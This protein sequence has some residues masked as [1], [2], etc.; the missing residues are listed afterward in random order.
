MI[1]LRIPQPWLEKLILALGLLLISLLSYGLLASKMGYFLDDWYIVST[2]RTFGASGFIGYFRGD[3]PLL[4]Y[5]YLL[6]MPIFKDSIPAW[7]IFAIFSKWLAALAF[8]VLLKLLFPDKK[9][10]P[11][12]TAMLFGIYPGFKFHYFVIMYSQ[13]YMMMAFYIVSYI[14]M[15]LSFRAKKHLWI[16]MLFALLCQLIGLAPMEYFFG[17]ELVRPV[18]VY[19]LVSDKEQTYWKNFKKTFQAWAPYAFV[20]FGYTAYR[21]LAGKQYSYKIN[22]LS[23]LHSS[24]LSTIISLLTTLLKGMFDSC[25]KAWGDFLSVLAESGDSRAASLRFGLIA[26]SFLISYLLFTSLHVK[27][28]E[29]KRSS[30]LLVILAVYCVLVAMIPFVFAGFQINLDFP[31]N[32]FMLPLSFGACLFIVTAVDQ[33]FRTQTQKKV[34]LALVVGSCVFGNYLNAREYKLAW[35]KQTDFFSQMLWRIP[36][37]K[38]ETTLLTPL[39]QFSTYFSGTSLTAPLNLIYAPENHSNPLP[40]QMILAASNEGSLLPALI[41]DQ[42]ISTGFRVFAFEGNTSDMLVIRVPEKGCLQL[43]SPKTNPASLKKEKYAELWKKILPLS[44][45]TRIESTM[46]QVE[47]PSQYFGS[48]NEQTW[49]YFYEKAELA[50]QNNNW[51]ESIALFE[52]AQSLSFKPE[53]SFEY[54]PFIRALYKNGKFETALNLSLALQNEDSFTK[55]ELCSFWSGEAARTDNSTIKEDANKI[56]QTLQCEW[57]NHD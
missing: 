54:L 35:Q 11:Y 12:A 23:D 18:I 44:N 10:L 56:M 55:S 16:L 43:L 2:Y 48:I 57:I 52:E 47:L 19:L 21:I 24:P 50:N 49:C 51:S 37:M 36:Q 22:L 8:W 1:K 32:R 40:Y 7:Q 15:L 4:S 34:I 53:N 26:A 30:G 42:K 9:L 5:V 41:P 17:L 45:F 33:L 31:N 46:S 38:P 29:E 20:F 39:M 6:F 28:A 13:T 14:L 27:K 25:F 3:R